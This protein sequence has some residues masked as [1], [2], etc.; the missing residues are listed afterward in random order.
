[1]KNYYIFTLSSVGVNIFYLKYVSDGKEAVMLGQSRYFG[2]VC[3]LYFTL[4]TFFVA[5]ALRRL[6][7]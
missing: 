3:A 2:V 5:N 4:I 1:M 6:R 7:M